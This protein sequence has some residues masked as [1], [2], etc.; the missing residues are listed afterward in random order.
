MVELTGEFYMASLRDPM[1]GRVYH[2]VYRLDEGLYCNL[3]SSMKCSHIKRLEMDP[4]FASYF[5]KF[6]RAVCKDCGYANPLDACYC[7]KCGRKLG[8]KA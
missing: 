6:K 1:D 4:D 3:C 7:I 8:V 5:E 2:I